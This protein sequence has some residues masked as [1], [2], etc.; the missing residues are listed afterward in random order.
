M[1]APPPDRFWRVTDWH[2]PFDPPP[3]PPPIGAPEADE[4]AA[5]RYD[6]PDG[7]FRTLYC[8]TEPD[9]AIGEKLGDFALDAEV[10][11]DIEEFFHDAPDDEHAADDLTVR[12]AAADVDG[13]NWAL[14]NA[15]PLPAA[16][17]IDLWNW[18]TLRAIFPLIAEL[19]RQ[20]RLKRD[21]RALLEER[22]GFTRRLAGLV[23]GAVTPDGGEPV[24]DGLRYESRLPPAWECWALWEPIP[25]DPATI[26][27]D[28]VTIDTPALRSAAAMLG[29][30][31]AE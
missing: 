31:L 1:V 5:G 11:R 24:A 7:S 2:D 26:D 28:R 14:A 15:V 30:P 20:F 19:L 29:V 16:R 6:A 9:G 27:V 3:P 25:I 17:F 18:R 4:D 22:R 13:F 8:C 21:R 10:A 23:R 12:L